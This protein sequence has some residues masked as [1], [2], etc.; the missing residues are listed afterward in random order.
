VELDK[1]LEALISAKS[2]LLEVENELST[3]AKA[4]P[5]SSGTDDD[6]DDVRD[7]TGG[8]LPTFSKFL[9]RSG[10][11]ARFL[12][13]HLI[14]DIQQSYFQWRKPL[15]RRKIMARADKIW[16]M[17]TNNKTEDVPP[18]DPFT[19]NPQ[20]AMAK[21]G[22][23]RSAAAPLV[24]PVSVSNKHQRVQEPT[25]KAK[26][27]KLPEGIT[28]NVICKK[29]GGKKSDHG[30]SKQFGS[31][32]IFRYCAR[33]GESLAYH[34]SRGLKMGFYCSVQIAPAREAAYEESL[35]R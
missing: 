3:Y 2:K 19:L 25:K 5:A 35:R 16:S 10:Y 14:E 27:S 8:T 9:D 28:F 1:K 6:D 15:M 13:C 23:K 21:V 20:V 34:Q 18:G 24:I 22:R 31:N 12:S 29:C 33:C 32:C 26:A 11:N 4:A 7:D 30:S 17:D